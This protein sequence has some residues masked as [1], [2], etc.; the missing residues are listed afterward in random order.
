MHENITMNNKMSFFGVN[1]EIVKAFTASYFHRYTVCIFL[2][3]VS[4]IIHGTK[5]QIFLR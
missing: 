1:M 3:T 4:F 2:F 5:Y